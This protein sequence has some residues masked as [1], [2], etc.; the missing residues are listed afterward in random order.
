[1]EKITDKFVSNALESTPVL[2][3]QWLPLPLMLFLWLAIV[4]WI[5]E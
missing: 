1:M 3:P 2:L 4:S 5:M